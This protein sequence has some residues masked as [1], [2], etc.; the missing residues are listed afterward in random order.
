MKSAS[1]A[2]FRLLAEAMPQIVWVTRPDGWNTY[3]NQQW[4]DYTGL[5]REESAGHGWNAPFHPDDRSDAW[6]A[7]QNATATGGTY[8]IESRLCRSDGVYRWWLVRGVPLKDAAGNILKWFGTCTDVHD[9]KVA[10]L[11]I[12][13]TN[14]ALQESER[15]FSDL[16]RNIDLISVMLDCE[17]RITYCND[18]LLRISG[19]QREEVIGQNWYKL[20]IPPGADGMKVRVFDLIA[21]LPSASHN[22][23]AILTRTGMRRVIRW[24][25]TLLRSTTGEVIGTASIG[26]DITERLELEKHLQISEE[27]FRSIFGAVSEGIF[28]IDAATGAVAEVNEPGAIIYGCARDEMIGLNFQS[29]SSNV[30][31]YTQRDAMG[32]I[33]KAATTGDPQRFDWH[34]KAK[35]GRLFWGEVSLRFAFIGGRQVVLSI[36]RDVT[37]LR[38][39]EGQLRQAQKMEAIGQLTGGIAHDFN[40]LLTVILSNADSLAEELGDNPDLRALAEITRT[41]AE[42][43]AELV[44][45]LLTFA[46]R[47][48]LE[49]QSVDI[50]KLL[51]GNY[52]LWRRALDEG[53][54]IKIIEGIELWQAVVDPVQ[55]ESAL[56]NLA[57]NAR[58]AM[59]NGGKLVIET[60]NTDV[61]VSSGN[62][63][64]K[65]APGR[66]VQ[67]C[68]SDTGTGMSKDVAARAFDPF[69]STKEVG[70]GT[71]LGLSMV[72]GFMK[73]SGGHIEIYSEIGLGTTF[74]IYLPVSADAELPKIVA[75]TRGDPI[76]M[77]TILAVEDDDLVRANTE[78]VLRSLGYKLLI[79]SNG[80]AAMTFL[81]RDDHIDL[82]FTDVVMPGG[83]SGRQLAEEACAM[84]PSLKVLFT[85]GYTDNPLIH[86]GRHGRLDPGVHLIRKPYRKWDLALKLRQLL[87]TNRSSAKGK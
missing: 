35:D 40:N 83:M 22:E 4:T 75:A 13:R 9:M 17:A 49:P 63:S 44:N 34:C 55:L 43:G 10:E 38:V 2:E 6:E 16:L 82:L 24:K 72:Y 78:R 69:F 66:Y 81:E 57:L 52:C 27:R 30:S 12:S 33:K 86:H 51:A 79:A 53:I 73:Q 41:A 62:N 7:W 25:N 19:W 64:D 15:R 42:R 37:D 76:G 14:L 59:P 20:F 1:E 87:D 74:R 80:P 11:E 65:A 36:V 46:R 71:G 56:L 54:D 3:F 32:W 77:E 29:I 31:P 68:V 47:Q 45:N 61:D 67:L 39:I 70:K 21:G 84:R 60:S 23:S 85:S 58:D 26:E 18:H 8:S 28:I 48:T 50:N 5:T